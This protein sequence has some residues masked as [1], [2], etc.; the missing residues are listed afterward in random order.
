MRAAGA[1]VR[2]R[3]IARRTNEEGAPFPGAPPS[4]RVAR[5]GSELV[6]SVGLLRLAMPIAIGA[7]FWPRDFADEVHVGV[8]IRRSAPFTST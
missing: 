7:A 2:E 3:A 5:S 1:P 8:A 6:R 4:I